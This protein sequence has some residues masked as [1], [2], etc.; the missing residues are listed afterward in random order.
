MLQ[1]SDSGQELQGTAQVKDDPLPMD[2]H[3]LQAGDYLSEELWKCSASYS[4][5]SH[6]GWLWL[7]VSGGLTMNEVEM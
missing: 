6:L 4:R 3:C 7:K 1:I 2:H 5:R